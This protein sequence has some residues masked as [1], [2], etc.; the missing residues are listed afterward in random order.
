ME[1]RYTREVSDRDTAI[2]AL[3]AKNERLEGEKGGLA[4]SLAALRLSLAEKEREKDGLRADLA[5]ARDAEVLSAEQ[6]R[7]A[8]ELAEGLRREL[9]SEKESAAAV[10]EQLSLTTRHLDSVKGVLAA[11]VGHYRAIVAEFGGE[12]SSPPEEDSV[13]NLASWLKRHLAK[14][15]DLLNGCTDYGA[16]AG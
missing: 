1:E 3:K 5:K 8:I 6:A 11:T 4:N 14:L 16:L 9:A 2:E 13:Y 15:P 7:R 10:G 12:T